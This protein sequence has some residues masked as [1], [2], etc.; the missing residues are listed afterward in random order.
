MK[1]MASARL[2]LFVERGFGAG[3]MAVFSAPMY[4]CTMAFGTDAAC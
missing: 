3:R 4:R 1:Y 2:A